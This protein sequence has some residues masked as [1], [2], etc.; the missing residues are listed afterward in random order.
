MSIPYLVYY[1]KYY[2]KPDKRDIIIEI[3]NDRDGEPIR[4]FVRE[5]YHNIAVSEP[6]RDKNGRIEFWRCAVKMEA[7]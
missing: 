3:T 6:L 2:V 5:E 7:V 4:P 1:F